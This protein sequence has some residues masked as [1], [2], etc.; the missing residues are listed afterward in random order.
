MGAV[1]VP[2]SR[3]HADGSLPVMRVRSV[4]CLGWFSHTRLFKQK[5]FS[6]WFLWQLMWY[7][8]H[9][10]FPCACGFVALPLAAL[11][12]SWAI[13]GLFFI[14][15]ATPHWLHRSGICSTVTCCHACTQQRHS[16]ATQPRR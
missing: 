15:G 16:H 11:V 12:G 10:I 1:K 3:M 8:L 13:P 4:H 9:H 6:A 14:L 7:F 5:N 2:Y